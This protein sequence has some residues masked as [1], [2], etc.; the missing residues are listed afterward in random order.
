MAI[1]PV[2]S[3][4][5]RVLCETDA[6]VY[7]L[8]YYGSEEFLVPQWWIGVSD[9][10]GEL[11]LTA[12]SPGQSGSPEGLKRWL[13]SMVGPAVEG[14]LVRLVAREIALASTHREMVRSGG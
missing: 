6:A 5:I 9:P 4:Q 8:R 7:D 14:H 10:D 2:A 11:R 12:V 13:R 1:E 3:A